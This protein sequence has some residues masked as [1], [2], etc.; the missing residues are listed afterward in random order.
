MGPRSKDRR[1]R[2]QVR[3]RKAKPPGGSLLGGSSF[4]RR[5]Q[6]FFGSKAACV[7]HLPPASGMNEK[8]SLPDST[9][10]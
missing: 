4:L 10:P 7:A 1:H 5:P 2:A 6:F 3:I 8:D 9:D